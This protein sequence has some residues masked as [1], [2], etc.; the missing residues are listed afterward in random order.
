MKLFSLPHSPYATRV[1]TLVRKAELDIE[2]CSPPETPRTPEFVDHFPMGKM[3][4]LELDDGSQLP[5]SWVIMRYLDEVACD[6]AYSPGGALARAHMELLARYADTYLAPGGLFPL[7]KRVGQGADEGDAAE[8]IAALDAELA[9]LD[10][11]L[12]MLPSF[13]DRPMH[14]GDMALVPHID[15]VLM[16]APMF[17]VNDPLA[18]HPRVAQGHAWTQVDSAVAESSAEMRAAVAAFFGA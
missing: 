11:V 8:D 18:A 10:R 17:G 4:V 2:I 6:S 15:F 1:R 12:T 3:P 9:R 13:A 7:F 14:M 16:L 5:D